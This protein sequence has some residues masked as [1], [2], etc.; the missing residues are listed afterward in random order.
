MISISQTLRR[1]RPADTRLG[2]RPPLALVRRIGFFGLVLLTTGLGTRMM[3]DILAA[4]GMAPIE[5]AVL[6]LFA[7]TFGWISISFW[8]AIA[9]GLLRAARL[10]PIQLRRRAEITPTRA[11]EI[12]GRTAILMP[13]YNEDTAAVLAR[14]DSMYRS[15]AKTG[16][17]DH[18]DFFVLSDSTDSGIAAMEEAGIAAL[19]RDLKARDRLFYRRRAEN[20]GR[21]AGNIADFCRRWGR[22]YD[23]MIVLDADSLMTGE[24]ILK[25]VATMQATPSA[26]IIQTVPLLVRRQ[27]PFARF[28]QFAMRAYGPMLANGLSFWQMGESQYWGHNA[29]LRVAAFTK[30]CGLPELPGRPPLGG[31]ILSHDFVESSLLRRHGWRVFIL[32]ELEGSYE[33]IPTNLMDFA[34]RDRRWAQ[35]NMQHL[36]LL[37]ASRLHPLS[38][39]Q[40]LLGALAYIS[41]LLWLALLALSTGEAIWKSVVPHDFFGNGHQLFPNWHVVREDSIIGLMAFTAAMLFLPKL[42]GTALLLSDPRSR[43]RFGGTRRLI[44]SALSETLF[45]IL[46]APLLMYLHAVFVVTILA[47]RSVGWLP[48]DREDGRLR[49]RDV[50]M[51]LLPPTLIGIAWAALTLIYVPAFFWWM[52]PVIVGLTISIPLTIYSSSPA[53]GRRLRGL[54]VFRIPEETAPPPVTRLRTGAIGRR[55]REALAVSAIDEL[56]RTPPET[57]T[58][59]PIQTLAPSRPGVLED[60]KRP[61]PARTTG[62]A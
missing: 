50:A 4:N 32:P 28:A 34:K 60:G 41:S 23:F 30:S 47:G 54:G 61:L 9:G 11:G 16:C 17:L 36:K 27:T 38:R 51:P 19:R 26:G 31:E 25:L 18:F 58:H 40:F 62:T 43:Q 24:A 46:V 57:P 5:S 52:L 8:T 39:F 56:P 10:D 49:L 2:A 22:R 59:M 29:I 44:V 12:R 48:Q 21:K 6:V 37:A 13:V 15:L 42:L 3:F 45:A 20:T 1:R 7:A 35:G 53:L 14:L 55:C 33:E